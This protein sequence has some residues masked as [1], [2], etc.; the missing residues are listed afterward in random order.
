ML[1]AYLFELSQ[2][3]KGLKEWS[4]G[5]FEG[6]SVQ[7]LDAVWDKHDIFG[8]RL[9][10]FGGETKNEVEHRI[11]TTLSNLL[12]S[13]NGKTFLAV[14]H[15]TAIQVFLRKWIGDDMAN[16]YVIG[17]CCILKFIYTHGKFKF[18]DMVDPTIDDANK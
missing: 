1:C 2:R 6:D 12:E 3:N 14:S 9:R 11:V 8:T 10:P 13:S 16:Q 15:G 4:F 17:N 7:L 5:L 18:L